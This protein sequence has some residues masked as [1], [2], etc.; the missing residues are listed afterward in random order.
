MFCVSDDGGAM[1]VDG[2]NIRDIGLHRVR[3]AMAIIPQDPILFTGSI[4]YN[5]VNEKFYFGVKFMYL[6]RRIHWKN[7]LMQ[8]YG[9]RWS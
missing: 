9:E 1:I 8:I 6:F 5:L 7:V 2:V 3:R 4:R